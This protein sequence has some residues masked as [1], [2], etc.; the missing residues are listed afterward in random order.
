MKIR[1]GTGI[2]KARETYSSRESELEKCV[3]VQKQE[4]RP[5]TYTKGNRELL[6]GNKSSPDVDT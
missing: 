2:F 4:P 3:K 1:M 6:Q 5:R